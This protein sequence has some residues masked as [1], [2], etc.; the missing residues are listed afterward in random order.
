MNDHRG[1]SAQQIRNSL[2]SSDFFIY[3]ALVAITGNQPK[4][5]RMAVGALM[6][7]TGYGQLELVA[8]IQR[9]ESK[10]YLKAIWFDEDVFVQ[11]HAFTPAMIKEIA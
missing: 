8:I 10:H 6:K 2:S 1:E 9:L 5:I 7:T 3:G 4:P 11:I